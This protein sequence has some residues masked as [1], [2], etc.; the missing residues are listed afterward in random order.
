MGK[1]FLPKRDFPFKSY[2]QKLIFLQRMGNLGKKFSV[3]R[4]AL[5]FC[6]TVA[7]LH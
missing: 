3:A 1:Q 2:N 5:E 6:M 4:G 7:Q